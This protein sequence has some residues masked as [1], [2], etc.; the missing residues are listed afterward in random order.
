M[1]HTNTRPS[2][3]PKLS[4]SSH[5]I[6]GWSRVP[7][8]LSPGRPIYPDSSAIY[9]LCCDVTNHLGIILTTRRVPFLLLCGRA[10]GMGKIYGVTG[11]TR[12]RLTISRT[13]GSRGGRGQGGGLVVFNIVLTI[14]IIVVIITGQP[15]SCG[16][17]RPTTQM[18]ISAMVA[19]FGG[20]T[21]GTD[22]GC[23]SGIVTIANRINAVRSRC[24]ALQTCSSSL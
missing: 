24:I 20:S 21:T 1:Y 5:P 15:G 22:R 17:S 13:V 12:I 16:F 19:S 3:L 14:V 23:S 9:T 18:A 2:R 8:R 6:T 7:A 11:S 10:V 4:P